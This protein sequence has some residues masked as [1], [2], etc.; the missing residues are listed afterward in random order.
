MTDTVFIIE[1]H[2]HVPL[3]E[4]DTYLIAHRAYLDESY[5]KG[6]FIASGPQHPRTGGIIMA[7]G[8][9]NDGNAVTKDILATIMDSD[10]FTIHK[11]ATYKI[12]EFNPVKFSE[13]FKKVMGI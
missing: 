12:T 11:L 5:K 9:D 1:L 2:Y 6:I 3:P 8:K 4:L 7:K 13:T 10:P